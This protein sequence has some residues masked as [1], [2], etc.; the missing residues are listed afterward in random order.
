MSLYSKLVL[1]DQ[2]RAAA[3]ARAFGAGQEEEPKGLLHDLFILAVVS[4]IV[5]IHLR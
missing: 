4:Y 2:A 1:A 5:Y 3:R